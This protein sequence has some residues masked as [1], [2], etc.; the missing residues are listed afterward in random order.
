MR[1]GP[2]AAA[3]SE[4]VTTMDAEQGGGGARNQLDGDWNRMECRS[5]TP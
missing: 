2:G 3:N 5:K 1:R 4:E